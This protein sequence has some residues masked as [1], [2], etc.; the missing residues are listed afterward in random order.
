MTRLAIGA[1]ALATA[2]IAAF[3]ITRLTAN[4]PRVVGATVNG[5]PA[6]PDFTLI[7]HHGRQIALHELRGKTVALTFIYTHCPDVC[8]L[9]A[10]TLGTADRRLG[11]Q[12]AKVELLA[13]SVDPA[14]DTPL[15]V[16]KF[17]ADRGLADLANW[18][19]L[20]GS[21]SQLAK[22]WQVYGGIEDPALAGKAVTPDQLAHL[23]IVYLIDPQGRLRVA[24]PSN[25]SAS[26]FLQDV[27][28]ISQSA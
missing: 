7:D 6:A 9:I 16:Q 2:V 3:G 27:Q 5:A 17:N 15:S 8:P 22:V 1:I 14:G 12:G 24:L 23:A 10:S 25:F 28:A 26:D 20:T 4:R 19:Y 13:V 18:H 11:A 21:P